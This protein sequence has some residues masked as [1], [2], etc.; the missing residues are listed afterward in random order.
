[1]SQTNPTPSVTGSTTDDHGSQAD[2]SDATETS[3]GRQPSY[4]WTYFKKLTDKP[5]NKC[6][7][8]NKDGRQC[9]KELA[10][11][12]RGG[13]TAM[14]NHLESQHG[15]RNANLPNQYNLASAFKKVKS[16]HPVSMKF[17]FTCH[18]KWR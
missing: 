7:F 4:V 12:K 15:V 2:Q 17:L 8:R 14:S 18:S 3:I 9:G 1:M 6:Q 13:T 5:Y 10:R 11:D 16:V